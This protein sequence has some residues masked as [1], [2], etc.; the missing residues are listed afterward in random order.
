MTKT[1]K[2][3]SLACAGV[4]VGLLIALVSVLVT[5]LPG[6]GCA[7]IGCMSGAG[8][9]IAVPDEVSLPAGTTMTAC[10]NDVCE[11]GT[12][13]SPAVGLPGTST[14]FEFPPGSGLS[15]GIWAAGTTGRDRVQVTW[16]FTND[17]PLRAGDHYS[18]TVTDPAGAVIATKQ[19]TAVW[20][21]T[22]K[23]CDGVCHSARF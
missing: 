15:G 3:Q 21:D 23:I 12:T 18:A 17:T 16:V 7:G 5:S 13:L 22:F 6:C 11:V 19:A 2:S 8:L 14:S 9:A 10:F 4:F 20:Y 1:N